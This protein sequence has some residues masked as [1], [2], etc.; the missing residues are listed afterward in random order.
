MKN[1][2]K[3]IK[4]RYK[5][6]IPIMVI[7]VLLVTIFFLYKEYKFDNRR[8]K[9]EVNV[10]QSFNTVKLEYTGVFTYNLKKALVDVTTKNGE[11][12]YNFLP[13]YYENMERVIFPNEM[14][15]VFPLFSGS[16]Y[17]TFKYASYYMVENL[18]YIKNNTD[19]NYYEKFFL[20]DGDGLFFFPEE[21]SLKI[22]GK[23]YKKL[24]PMS[25]VSVTGRSSL[26]YYDAGSDTAEVME[27]D[28]EKI[29]VQ[30]EYLNVNLIDQSFYSFDTEVL[31][32]GPN[33][34]K[35]LFKTID[36]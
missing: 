36:K 4:E 5:L 2:V 3:F 11:I 1:I 20:Y 9:E 30:N 8:N 33:N 16:Q 13:I 26:V 6:L 31:L 27:I 19:E 25:F 7:V 24:G 12:L 15:V 21:V 28:R 10:F 34:L 22:D 32:F 18:H 29:T 17:K 23:E 35:P 14:V